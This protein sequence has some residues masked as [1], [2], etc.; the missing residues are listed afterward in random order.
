M[1]TMTTILLASATLAVPAR[2][3]DGEGAIAAPPAPAGPKQQEYAAAQTAL[4][5]AQA[6][7]QSATQAETD[8]KASL[9]AAKATLK[10]AEGDAKTAA[11]AAADQAKTVLDQ[12]KAAAKTAKSDVSKAEKALNKAKK[13]ADAEARASTKKAAKP[14]REKL[15]TQN[16]VARPKGDTATGRAWT[17]FDDVSRANGTPASIGEA[18]PLAKSQGINEA[19]VRTQYARWRKYNNVS[20]RIAAPAAAPAAQTTDAVPPAPPAPPVA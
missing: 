6:V 16:G 15:P 5:N 1:K 18:M 2:A 19:T 17:I 7:L 3:F 11:K 12:A 20:G 9:E 14:A 4:T 10:A 8:A 13:A